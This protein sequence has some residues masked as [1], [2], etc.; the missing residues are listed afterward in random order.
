MWSYYANWFWCYVES[1]YGLNI[2][3]TYIFKPYMYVYRIFALQ[4]FLYASIY[5]VF[6][7]E[8][9]KQHY[10]M[11]LFFLS[12][13]INV[14]L[15][16]QQTKNKI[17]ATN[18]ATLLLIYT[19]FRVIRGDRLLIIKS[20]FILKIIQSLMSRIYIISS[21]SY[22]NWLWFKG[23]VVSDNKFSWRFRVEK[24]KLYKVAR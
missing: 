24:E 22:F 11:I 2:C 17:S 6:H 12:R 15:T 23:Q 19:I 20:T 21:S 4:K 16:H 1:I 5:I 10:R 9:S 13:Q 7:V 8:N 14:E 18:H 3:N